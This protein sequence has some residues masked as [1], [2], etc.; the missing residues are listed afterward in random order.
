M[1][2]R[3]IIER[4]NGDRYTTTSDMRPDLQEGDNLIGRC[5]TGR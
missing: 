2:Y 4:P 5:A 3:W 1:K